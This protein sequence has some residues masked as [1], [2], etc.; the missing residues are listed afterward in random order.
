M[1][2][3]LTRQV[4]ACK[5]HSWGRSNTRHLVMAEEFKGHV[6]AAEVPAVERGRQ[7]VIAGRHQL[8]AVGGIPGDG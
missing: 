2:S 5:E 4:T 7:L 6:G 3:G 1:P 8:R